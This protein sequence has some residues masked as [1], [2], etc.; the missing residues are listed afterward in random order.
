MTFKKMLSLFLAATLLIGI[1]SCSKDEDKFSTP[2]SIVGTWKY[3]KYDVDFKTSSIITDALVKEYIKRSDFT[4]DLSSIP[5]TITFNENGTYKVNEVESGTYTYS[6]GKLNLIGFVDNN[7]S[8]TTVTSSGGTLKLTYS[9]LNEAAVA[10][11]GK[12]V[13]KLDIVAIFQKQ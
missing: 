4:Q 3:E 5:K 9:I 1:T 8:N 10:V 12:E 11:L 2:S 7:F 6:N 13:S